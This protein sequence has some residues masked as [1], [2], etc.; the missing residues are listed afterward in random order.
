MENIEPQSRD[1]H[2]SGANGCGLHQ[3][4]DCKWARIITSNTHE[5][6]HQEQETNQQLQHEKKLVSLSE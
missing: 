4:G 3:V 6:N 1:A 5:Q 2:G